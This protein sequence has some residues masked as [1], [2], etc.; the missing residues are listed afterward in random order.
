MADIIIRRLET[1]RELDQAVDLQ[2]IYWGEDANNLVPRHMLHSLCHHGGH[3][4][5]AWLDDRL[6]GF[7]MGFIGAAD[8]GRASDSLLIMSKRMLVTPGHRGQNIGYQLKVAQREIARSQGIPLITWTFDPLLSANAHLN[9]RKL[10]ASIRGYAVNYFGLDDG[11]ALTSDRLIV[12]WRVKD[13]G[14]ETR[15][16]A[17]DLAHYF[18]RG[19]PIVNPGMAA[20]DWIAPAVHCQLSTAPACLL[21]IPADI[22]ALAADGPELAIGWRRHIRD[23]FPRQ[24]NSGYRVIDLRTWPGA[25]RPARLLPAQPGITGGKGDLWHLMARRSHSSGLA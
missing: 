24:L 25:G 16:A 1:T 14:G 5:G 12:D 17:A 8:R 13:P 18:E 20:G 11:E 2:K 6:L 9:I 4:L 19:T 10:G 23:I 3:V 15:A 21:E 22:R 7:V